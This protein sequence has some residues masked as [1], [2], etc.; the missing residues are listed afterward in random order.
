MQV[1]GRQSPLTVQNLTEARKAMYSGKHGEWRSTRKG[2]TRGKPGD[3]RYMC[4]EHEGCEAPCRIWLDKV[5][6]KYCLQVHKKIQ[7]CGTPL[8]K[9]RKASI[10]TLSFEKT[11]RAKARQGA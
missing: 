4:N 1:D 8:V 3:R 6:G 10:F 9:K 7:H 11:A 5:S 2:E